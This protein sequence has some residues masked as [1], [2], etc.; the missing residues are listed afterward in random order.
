MPKISEGPMKYVLVFLALVM[1][2]LSFPSIKVVLDEVEPLTLAAIRFVIPLPIIFLFYSHELR[3]RGLRG[4]REKERGYASRKEE[5][6]G[7]TDRRRIEEEIGEVKCVRNGIGKKSGKEKIFEKNIGVLV[8]RERVGKGGG[9]KEHDV[10][11][12]A[13][14]GIFNV[15]LPNIFQNYGMQTTPSGVTSIIQGSGPIFTILLA[16]FF[17]REKLTHP[18]VFGVILAFVGSL[19]LVTEGRASFDGST[20]GKFLILLSAV[21]YA[22]S[23]VLAKILLRKHYAAEITLK[24]FLVGGSMLIIAAFLIENPLELG[25]LEL[26]YWEHILYISLFPTC[27]A[28]IFWF[29]ALVHFPLSKIAITIFLIPVMAVIFSFIF[30]G[31][32]IDMYTV[33]TGIMVITGV[34][35]SQSFGK[36]AASYGAKKK[37]NKNEKNMGKRKEMEKK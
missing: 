21:S 36:K 9:K 13:F 30:L 22:I 37:G 2:A 23:G 32:E 15:V 16:A 34:I 5:S 18:Q 7:I 14:F 35:I 33:I 17:L 1:W 11:L 31:E 4:G 6:G 20:W 27:F 25:D 3:S 26:L 19:L 8:K 28:Y 29:R 10:L 24:S 12:F